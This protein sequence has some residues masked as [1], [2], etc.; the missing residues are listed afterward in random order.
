MRETHHILIMGAAYGSLLSE[1]V[2]ADI[3]QSRSVYDWVVKLCLRLGAAEADQCA[4]ASGGEAGA[5]ISGLC[6]QENR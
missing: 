4:S 5:Q 1:A 6:P 2:H 3:E